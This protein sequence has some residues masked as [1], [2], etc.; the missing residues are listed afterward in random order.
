MT[1]VDRTWVVVGASERLPPG[2]TLA[3]DEHDVV[4]W[5]T[6]GGAVCVVDSRCPHQWSHLDA[7][8]VVDGEELVCTAHFWRFDRAGR[9]TKVNVNGR[10]D[11]KAD[12]DVFPSREADGV[13]WAELPIAASTLDDAQ[14][15][16]D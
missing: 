14:P 12:L 1:L 13:I 4:V 16:M 3:D 5:R 8:G 15:E 11:I 10:R 6:A 7:E 2:S 9:G